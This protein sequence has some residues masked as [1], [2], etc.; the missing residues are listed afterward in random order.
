MANDYLLANVGRPGVWVKLHNNSTAVD[1]ASSAQSDGNG[2]FIHSAPPGRYTL[3]AAPDVSLPAFGSSHWVA[4]GDTDY[5]VALTAG[6]DGVFRSGT[7]LASGPYSPA[8][9]LLPGNIALANYGVTSQIKVGPTMVNL[10]SE[11][12][13]MTGGTLSDAAVTSGLAKL[14][15]GG[16]VLYVPPGTMHISAHIPLANAL[17]LKGDGRGASE[18]FWAGAASTT[19]V[20]TNPG[21][22][23]NVSYCSIEGIGLNA[24]N[25]SGVTPLLLNS[26]QHGFFADLLIQNV[27]GAT[28]PALRME[29]NAGTSSTNNTVGNKFYGLYMKNIPIG[30]RMGGQLSGSTNTF[31]TNNRFFGLYMDSVSVKG[32]Q[33]VQW[34]DS[35]AWYGTEIALGT[36]NAVGIVLNDSATPAGDVGVYNTNFF[37][38]SIDSFNITGAVG[39][40]GNWSKQFII[41]GLYHSPVVFNGTLFVDSN[42]QSYDMLLTQDNNSSNNLV[43]KMKNMALDSGTGAGLGAYVNYIVQTAQTT[44]NGPLLKATGNDANI[45]LQL[46]G[47]GTGRI[48]SLSDVLLFGNTRFIS[49]GTAPTV[50]S[51]GA[52]TSALSILAGSTNISGRFQVTLTAVAPGVVAGVVAFNGGPLAQA[53][54]NVVCSL[55]AP[56]AGVAAPPVVGADTFTTSGFTI[57]VYGPTTVT[58][59]TYVINYW[60]TF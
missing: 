32:I 27:A 35:N 5:P 26:V 46:Q 54:V 58:T 56:T 50:G 13:D 37:H 49:S 39:I 18:I 45:D 51:G 40:Q 7:F 2:M 57:R 22:G 42:I 12:A 47:T 48:L 19:M 25:I 30:L 8:S 15:N 14:P 24:N 34:C 36:N 17:K 9:G 3:Y 60:V 55:S 44:G 10:Q 43:R 4:T 33:L 20:D 16:G 41:W 31:S 11:G 52:G 38:L 28:T 1:Y 53:P 23:V 59:G 29:V 21:A 6:D